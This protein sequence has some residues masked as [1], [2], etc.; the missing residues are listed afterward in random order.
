[1]IAV[2]ATSKP[3]PTVTRAV[4]KLAMAG[5]LGSEGQVYGHEQVLQQDLDG[6]DHPVEE[7]DA[8]HPAVAGVSL[9]S[10]LREAATELD[11]PG[12]GGRG[13]VRSGPG[14]APRVS[15]H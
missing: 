15:G 2:S 7:H 1:M 10:V 14:D 4:R 6:S 12:I 5:L 9:L 11:A 13:R 8:V 3:S